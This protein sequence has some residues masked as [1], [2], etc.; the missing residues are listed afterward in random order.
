MTEAA[1]AQ[2]LSELI[3]DAL[4]TLDEAF[5]P[6]QYGGRIAGSDQQLAALATGV[7]AALVV[8]AASIGECQISLPY[9]AIQ[10]VRHPDGSREWC[11]SHSPRHCDP[12]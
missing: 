11:C 1:S 2:P 7:R 6:L 8:L 3:T 5:G 12:V 10:L 4:R 9:A